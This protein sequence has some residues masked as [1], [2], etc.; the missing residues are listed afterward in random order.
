M[1]TTRY[2]TAPADYDDFGT[3]STVVGWEHDR[4]V[5]R[6]EI[7]DD[8]LEWQEGRYWSGCY[9]CW[10]ERGWFQMLK[11]GL[12]TTQPPATVVN[13]ELLEACES[14]AAWLERIAFW[15]E[16]QSAHY[17]QGGSHH[18]ACDML[19]QANK[20]RAAAKNAKDHP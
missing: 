4:P 6:V 16:R 8:H 5:R 9:A 15:L 3:V 11:C 17:Q 20:L 18:A 1:T 14:V 19:V 12:A 2:T 10:D 7:A 13:A